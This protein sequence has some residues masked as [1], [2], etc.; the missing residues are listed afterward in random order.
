MATETRRQFHEALLV[1]LL[2]AR[3]HSR[4]GCTRQSQRG[5][6]AYR[7]ALTSGGCSATSADDAAPASARRMVWRVRM[8]VVLSTGRYLPG[9]GNMRKRNQPERSLTN[10][11]ASR[12]AMV[13]AY[14]SARSEGAAAGYSLRRLRDAGAA[15][16]VLNPA[17]KFSAG[18]IRPAWTSALPAAICARTC[19]FMS[20]R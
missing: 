9:G 10:G 12:I 18:R 5:S 20:S 8:G 17:N 4:S 7:T 15:E 16:A 1:V 11:S 6:R 2:F 13:I 14:C 3:H 19:G